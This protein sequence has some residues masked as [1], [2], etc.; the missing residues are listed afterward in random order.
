MINARTITLFQENTPEKAFLNNIEEAKN[1]L[2]FLNARTV[3]IASLNKENS[4][5]F[6]KNAFE[7][8]N[9]WGA[10]E[11]ISINNLKED[12]E[13]LID[14]IKRSKN[15]FGFVDI[16]KNARLTAENI[17][18]ITSLVREVSLLESGNGQKNFQLGIGFNIEEY[19]PY[20]PYSYSLFDNKNHDQKTKISIGLEIVNF[21]KDIIE[22]NSRKSIDVIRNLIYLSLVKEVKRI[23]ENVINQLD[24]KK[25]SFMGFDISYSPFPYLHGEASVIELIEKIGNIGRSRS[26][27]KFKFGDPGTQFIHTIFTGITKDIRENNEIVTSGFC[28]MMYSVLEDNILSEYYS[29]NEINYTN[30]MLLSTTCGCG[31]DMLP[32]NKNIPDEEIYGYLL[33]MFCLSNRLNKPLGVRLL[34]DNNKNNGEITNYNDVFLSNLKL[35]ES[36]NG[37]HFLKLPCQKS[38]RIKI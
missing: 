18:L 33:D 5:D 12:S 17:E 30:L 31:I 32:L 20:F 10:S 29:S 26:K 22:K 25:F 27:I 9:I 2:S 1:A 19:T 11:K 4:S 7:N 28:S 15:Y 13:R 8:K 3:R 24:S 36:Y 23:Q 37:P 16:N 34:I 38:K 35:Q 21:V 6:L 14:N